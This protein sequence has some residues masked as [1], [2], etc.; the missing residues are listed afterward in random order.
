MADLPVCVCCRLL[1]NYLIQSIELNELF[2]SPKGRQREHD[3]Y[4]KL[5]NAVWHALCVPCSPRPDP[6]GSVSPELPVL[7]P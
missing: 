5:S 3:L 6:E 2:R 4:I 1:L 7:D